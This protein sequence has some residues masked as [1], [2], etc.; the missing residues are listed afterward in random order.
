MAQREKTKENKCF[1]SLLKLH[2]FLIAEKGE[3]L[4]L[5]KAVCFR[6]ELLYNSKMTLC[7]VSEWPTAFRNAFKVILDDRGHF[8]TDI[9]SVIEASAK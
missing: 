6:L 1:R 5:V 9:R 7:G 4:L 8:Q 2:F 3:D